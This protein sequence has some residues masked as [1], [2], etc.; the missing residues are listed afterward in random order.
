VLLECYKPSLSVSQFDEGLWPSPSTEI[1]FWHITAVP[2]L[3]TLKRQLHISPFPIMLCLLSVSECCMPIFDDLCRV[4]MYVHM[5]ALVWLSSSHS[6]QAVFH[7]CCAL[8]YSLCPPLFPVPSTL[9]ES[10]FD[11]VAVRYRGYMSKET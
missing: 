7:P 9:P 10:H 4:F 11:L 3:K 6:V 8:H 1:C 2:W 5:R